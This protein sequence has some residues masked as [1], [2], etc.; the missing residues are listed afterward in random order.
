MRYYKVETDKTISFFDEQNLLALPPEELPKL[1]V[2]ESDD[3]FVRAE[4]GYFYLK[5]DIGSPEYNQA[6]REF[7][8][9]NEVVNLRRLLAETDYVVIKIQEAQLEGVP[10]EVESLKAR[11][12][13]I[14][15]QRRQARTRLN[16]LENGQE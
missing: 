15:T 2:V 9:T 11:Y 14:L 16:E 3:D 1:E 7:R 5:R 13:E 4:T 12:Q 8:Q 10:E 6:V